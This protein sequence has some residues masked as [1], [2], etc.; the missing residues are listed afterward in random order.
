M[1]VHS[2]LR[3]G[4]DLSYIYCD[5]SV[6][7]MDEPTFVDMASPS[8]VLNCRHTNSDAPNNAIGMDMNARVVTLCTWPIIRNMPLPSLLWAQWHIWWSHATQK[9]KQT[10]KTNSLGYFTSVLSIKVSSNSSY[11]CIYWRCHVARD[12]QPTHTY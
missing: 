11:M 12:L 6:L 8:F 7:D 10:K 2:P 4:G 5:N 1:S 9:Q 3:N